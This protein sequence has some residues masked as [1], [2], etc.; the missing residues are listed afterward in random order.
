MPPRP[1]QELS[2]RAR[3]ASLRNIRP[4]LRMVWKTS[5]PLVMASTVFR[6]L[7][8]LLPLAM[9]WVS[10]VIIDGVVAWITRRSGILAG[11]WKLVALKLAPTLTSLSTGLIVF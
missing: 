4:L 3:L 5:P 11:I 8:A 6:L 10:K 9:P 7:R 1:T 2:W